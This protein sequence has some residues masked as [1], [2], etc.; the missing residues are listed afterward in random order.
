M[1]L[2][3]MMLDCPPPPFPPTPASCRH[4]EHDPVLDGAGLPPLPLHL[5]PADITTMTLFLMTLDCPTPP[6]HPCLLQTL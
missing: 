5:P 6:P 1:T 4:H 3:L 2:F